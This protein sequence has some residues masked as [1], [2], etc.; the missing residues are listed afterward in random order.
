MSG[1]P[2]DFNDQKGSLAASVSVSL[3]PDPG[4][5]FG[6][7]NRF[8]CDEGDGHQGDDGQRPECGQLAE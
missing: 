1:S 4:A 6:I 7:V 5:Q 2:N 8:V 3:M